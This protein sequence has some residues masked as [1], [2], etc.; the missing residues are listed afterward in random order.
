MMNVIPIKT[1]KSKFK[2]SS[3]AEKRRAVR[4]PKTGR[5]KTSIGIY[6][7]IYYLYIIIEIHNV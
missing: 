6:I 4:N 1:T 5:K 7:Y 3:E 2:P